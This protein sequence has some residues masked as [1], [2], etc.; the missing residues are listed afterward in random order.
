[1]AMRAYAQD[2]GIVGEDF[3]IFRIFLAVL[4]DEW[5]KH[6]AEREKKRDSERRK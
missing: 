5:L 6:V 2:H 1:M 3:R 4:D